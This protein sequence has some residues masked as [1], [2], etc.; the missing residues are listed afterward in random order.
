MS[1]RS[2]K[3]N[4]AGHGFAAATALAK[5]KNAGGGANAGAS[6]SSEIARG[7]AVGGAD[8]VGEMMARLS[9]MDNLNLAGKAMD[10]TTYEMS[11]G[12]EKQ[13]SLDDIDAFERRLEGGGPAKTTPLSTKALPPNIP[14]SK[15][16]QPAL[17]K[18]LLTKPQPQPQQ[19][20]QPS[21]HPTGKATVKS[22]KADDDND[23]MSEA[24]DVRQAMRDL[25]RFGYDHG[26]D[27]DEDS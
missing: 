10:E 3:Q 6:T 20:K 8:A 27:S 2:S 18:P 19:R 16:A 5:S 22:R 15:L 13:E 25:D 23:G 11:D 17:Q 24:E 7:A 4:P 26:A 12:D 21:Q 14:G 9:A 1:Q